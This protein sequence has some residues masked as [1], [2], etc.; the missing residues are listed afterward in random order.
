MV[1]EILP[2][3]LKFVGLLHDSTEAYMCDIPRPIKGHLTNYAE[4]EAQLYRALA[5]KFGL[6]DKL[7]PEVKWA[8]NVALMTEAKLVGDTSRWED[9]GVK[10]LDIVPT[11]WTPHEARDRFLAMYHEY[12]VEP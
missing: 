8:D 10:P 5:K 12:S 6:P 9:F 3:E 11:P 7:P 2:Q 4:Y 1:A